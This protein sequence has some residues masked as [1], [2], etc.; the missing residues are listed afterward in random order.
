M[1]IGGWILLGLMVLN[2]LGW[3]AT[4]L[5]VLQRRRDPR[6]GLGPEDP[7]GDPAV[8][9]SV[10]VPA[11]NEEAHIAGC[12]RAILAQDHPSLQLVVQ[13]DGSTDRTWEIL[14]EFADDPRVCL[15]QGDDAPL[16]EG[17]FGKPWALQRAQAHATGDWLVFVDADVRLAPACVSRIVAHADAHELG[18]VTGLGTLTMETFWERVLQPA[19]AGIILMG[20]DLDR[21]NDP[22]QPDH[23]L[24]S[25]QFL[26]FRRSAYDAIGGHQPVAAD[27]LDDI[28]LARACTANDVRYHCLLMRRLYSVRMY[29]GFREIWEGW[30]KNLFAGMHHSWRVVATSLSFLFVSTL[31]G[32]LVALLWAL[33]WVSWPAGVA[34]LCHLLVIQLVRGVLD[35]TYGHKVIYGLSHVPAT[36]MVMALMVN[37]GLKSSG[38]G[39]TWKGRSYKPKAEDAAKPS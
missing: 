38:G 39:V 3:L 12:V 32:P 19:V 23:N 18:M 2:C 34:G 30:S 6:W 4:L 20:N 36:A 16:P 9:V 8:T 21:V 33:G 24:A 22:E 15:V 27:I 35:A 10:V 25:G 26:A 14:Q 29:T 1:G 28:G 5:K 37:S 11:R 31:S 17:W 7:A 13:D